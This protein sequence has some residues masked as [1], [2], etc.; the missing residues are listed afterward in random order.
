M[1]Q[2]NYVLYIMLITASGC[3]VVQICIIFS[4]VMLND[5]PDKQPDLFFYGECFKFSSQ[6]R[7]VTVDGR[8]I[9]TPKPSIDMFVVDCHMCANGS[10]MEDIFKLTDIWEIVELVSCFGKSMP[11]GWNSN[12]S[13]ELARTFYINNFSNKET[14]HTILSY[15]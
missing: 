2:F 8:V 10:C 14:F 7:D 6:Y 9:C 5:S 1:C 3:K 4:P 12:N 11:D 13:L 15:Q